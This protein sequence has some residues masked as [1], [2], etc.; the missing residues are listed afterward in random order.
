MDTAPTSN[1]EI[2]NGSMKEKV[3]C[4]NNRETRYIYIFSPLLLAACHKRYSPMKAP[5]CTGR[6]PSPTTQLP[7]IMDYVKPILLN[8]QFVPP[9][10]AVVPV[11]TIKGP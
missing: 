11:K 7:H 5:F 1:H 10:A 9:A 6:R 3:D 2:R 4:N 8:T